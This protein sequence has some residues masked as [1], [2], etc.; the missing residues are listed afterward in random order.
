[1]NKEIAANRVVH[2]FPLLQRKQ[3][4]SE[5]EQIKG[6]IQSRQSIVSIASEAV[7]KAVDEV[8]NRISQ[9]LHKNK[10][11]KEPSSTYE[12][13][14]TITKNQKLWDEFRAELQR[15]NAVTGLATKEHLFIFLRNNNEVI[16]EQ[17]TILKQKEKEELSAK[18]T[19]KR[20]NSISDI[21]GNVKGALTSSRSEPNNLLHIMRDGFKFDTN[22]NPTAEK[23]QSAK[24]KKYL[25]ENVMHQEN[26]SQLKRKNSKAQT[27]K[28]E[29][30]EFTYNNELTLI[31]NRNERI[32]HAPHNVSKKLSLKKGLTFR[33]NRYHFEIEL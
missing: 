5:V 19:I 8:Q 13:V 25:S 22:S 15:N 14:N 18:S 12:L 9:V 24:F 21:L 32:P 4:S 6:T 2:I 29:Y 16:E 23:K 17:H 10:V 11:E 1:M 33:E 28:S 27:T 3:T 30:L 31:S 7:I 20:N 26:K